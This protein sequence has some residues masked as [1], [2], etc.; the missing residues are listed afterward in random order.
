[1]QRHHGWPTASWTARAARECARDSGSVH[2]PASRPR[3][4]AMSRTRSWRRQPPQ[5]ERPQVEP[6]ATTPARWTSHPRRTASPKSTPCPGAPGP[7]GWPGT[8]EPSAAIPSLSAPPRP[9]RDARAGPRSRAQRGRHGGRSE[10]RSF[11]SGRGISGRRWCLEAPSSSRGPPARISA[12]A[13]PFVEP[14]GPHGQDDHTARSKIGPQCR[15]D[16][17]SW[18][19]DGEGRD[20]RRL[21]ARLSVSLAGQTGGHVLTGMSSGPPAR[22]GDDPAPPELAVRPED[23][24]F[25][26]ATAAG[27]ESSDTRRSRSRRE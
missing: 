13:S 5:A 11:W 15:V 16:A 1:M 12:S 26:S 25:R 9:E 6:A 14:V 24:S 3:P 20:V 2:S 18:G 21:R 27:R 19:T 8:A 22:A 17:V 23:S 10:T 4:K 7:A